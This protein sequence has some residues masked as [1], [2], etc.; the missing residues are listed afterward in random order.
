MANEQRAI[1]LAN[2]Q[3]L[4]RSVVLLE[5]KGGFCSIHWNLRVRPS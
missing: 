3:F 4:K 5:E 2:N 1:D